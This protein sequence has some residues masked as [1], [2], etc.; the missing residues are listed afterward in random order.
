[1]SDDNVIQFPRLQRP[2]ETPGDAPP[3][4]TLER[5]YHHVGPCANYQHC[6][7]VDARARAIKCSRCGADL[8]PFAVLEE[9]A[10]HHEWHKGLLSEVAQ[11]RR[12]L[13]ALTDE[14]AK[15][16]ATRNALRRKTEGGQ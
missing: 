6:A 14:V 16:R 10:K 5:G 13:A 2:P 15:M 11:K 9:V 4:V 1:M 12:E 8:D 3:A 7:A